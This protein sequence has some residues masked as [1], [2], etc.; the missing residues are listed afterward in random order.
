MP[1]NGN[2]KECSNS[3]TIVLISRFS[4]VML[5]SF[6]LDF[7]STWTE[8]FQMYKLDLQ[9]AEEPEMELPHSLGHTKS[10]GIPEKHLLLFHWLH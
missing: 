2:A 3:H 7:S 1:K 4:K 9:K 10:K 6:K 5:K 8:N